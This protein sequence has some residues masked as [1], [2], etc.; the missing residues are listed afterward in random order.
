MKQPFLMKKKF[1]WSDILFV[2][3]IVLLIIP[4]TRKP[5][6][7]GINRLKIMVWSPSMES[8]ETAI[9]VP[10]FD[11]RV[12][13]L[14]GTKS[15]QRIGDG[16]IT[17]L[18]FW[19][20]WC[21]PCVAELPSIIA[22]HGDY[23]SEVNFVLATRE[24]PEVVKPFLEKKGYHLPVYFPLSKVPEGLESNSL[25]TNYLIDGD[26]TIL[27]KETGAANWNSKKVRNVLDLLLKK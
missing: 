25:P 6:Q 7:V 10:A 16:K 3:F 13:D 4:Q 9:K 17:F 21:A 14:E 20:T 1:N 26:G 5:I 15:I 2:V 18:S 19:A 27:I 12:Q 8:E 22:L 11:Y 23:G 24:S